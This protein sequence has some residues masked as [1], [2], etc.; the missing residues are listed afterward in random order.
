MLAP[1]SAHGSPPYFY[2][3]AEG[4]CDNTR[5]PLLVIRFSSRAVILPPLFREFRTV[6]LMS[7]LAAT[8]FLAAHA[9]T[10]CTLGTM[11][12]P[13]P[14][15]S[16]KSPAIGNPAFSDRQRCDA[17]RF[18]FRSLPP[19]ICGC[20]GKLTGRGHYERPPHFPTTHVNCRVSLAL[21]FAS[22]SSSGSV[23]LTMCILPLRSYARQFRFRPHFPTMLCSPLPFGR[24]SIAGG[25]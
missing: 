20:S 6:V 14:Y 2:E 4:F 3:L 8:V 11:M 18:S 9:I 16:L 24:C 25:G 10:A 1:F 15:R 19:F 22:S 12:I 23:A 17:F 7:L 13:L 21:D 5:Y